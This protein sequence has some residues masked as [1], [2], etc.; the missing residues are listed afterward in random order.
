MAGS[1]PRS[2]IRSDSSHRHCSFVRRFFDDSFSDLL[3]RV[4]EEYCKA[5]EH[6]DFSYMSAQ[7]PQPAVTRN[8]LFNWIP[9]VPAIDL[10]DRAGSE[11]AV[12]CSAIR[13]THPMIK[14]LELDMEPS[15]VLFEMDEEIVG[16]VQFPLSRFPVHI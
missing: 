3:K 16:D 12:T 13:F 2:K 8:C 4:T 15:V 9:Q 11:N 7:I 5:S 14:T 6:A 1:A 10:S